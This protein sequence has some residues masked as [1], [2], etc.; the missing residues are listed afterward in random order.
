MARRC[1]WPEQTLLDGCLAVTVGLVTL[2]V[3][4]QAQAE[5]F[6]RGAVRGT[7]SQEA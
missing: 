1:S 2:E 6:S 4:S 5:E 3:L 7:C